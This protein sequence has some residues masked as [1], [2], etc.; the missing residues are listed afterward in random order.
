[1]SS[2]A[3]G[4]PQWC[5]ER[6]RQ[7]HEDL[8]LA[9]LFTAPDLRPAIAASGAIYIEL[10]AIALK[11]TD[12]NIARAKFDWWREELAR[13]DAGRPAHP[14]TRSL[15]AS[16]VPPPTAQLH[17]LVTGMELNLLAGPPGD[18][19]AAEFW[20]ERGFANL[21][22]VLASQLGS[23]A[24]QDYRALG[25][26]IGIARCLQA[27]LTDAVRADIAVAAQA[28]LR[29]ERNRLRASPPALR[30]L[31]GLAWRRAAQPGGAL[32]K[33]DERRRVFTAWRAAR[34]KLPRRL[35]SQ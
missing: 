10:E 22:P 18:R 9:R 30:V 29:E 23:D 28:G 14:A 7:P 6:L 8:R 15:A 27:P 13:L 3:R 19:S 25:A 35:R 4:A 2:N 21:T 11:F 1:M 24:A 17:D 16:A 31:V 34:G 5:E 12:L 26:S 32:V 33:Q 20:G